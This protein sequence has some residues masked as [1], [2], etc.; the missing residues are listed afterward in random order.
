MNRKFAIIIIVV[1]L[2][3]LG[4]AFGFDNVSELTQN[5]KNSNKETVET[6][7]VGNGEQFSTEKTQI[8][9]GSQKAE[10]EI[11]STRTDIQPL[12][13][14]D[15]ILKTEISK[16]SN[17]T[18]DFRYNKQENIQ[19]K[20]YDISFSGFSS[21]YN[22]TKVVYKNDVGDEFEYDIE[23]GK[24]CNITLESNVVEKNVDSIDIEA[25]QKIALEYFPKGCNINEYTNDL[26]VESKD[27]YAVWY[28]R[29]IGKYITTDAFRIKIGF[30]GSIVY[31][32]D[33]TDVFEGKNI[34]FDESYVDA[35]IAE[36]INGEENLELES[37]V[38]LEDNGQICA[39]CSFSQTFSSG[40]I[41]AYNINIPIK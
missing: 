28:T 10:S 17:T 11:T 7:I 21:N 19:G 36:Y 14:D 4:C 37:V 25:A 1:L 8:S 38:I 34:N 13:E 18:V 15:N 40:A 9:Q 26:C 35:K 20:G 29:F 12:T 22:P 30:D 6:F 5:L 39:C 24:L 32:N 31:I 3:G 2:I 27:G 41:S 23:T 16:Y 33:A